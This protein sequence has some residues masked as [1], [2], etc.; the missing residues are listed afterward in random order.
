[1]NIFRLKGRNAILFLLNHFIGYMYIVYVYPL[2]LVVSL[3][4][5][6]I[7]CLLLHVKLTIKKS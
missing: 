2:V 6:L 4:M 1:M 5:N 3:F 7:C